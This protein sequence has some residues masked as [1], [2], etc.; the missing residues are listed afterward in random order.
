MRR[1]I[2]FFQLLGILFVSNT[3]F[4]DELDDAMELERS[5]N[6]LQAVTEYQNW[7]EASSGDSRFPDVLIHTASLYTHPV[8][9]LDTLERYLTGLKA[10]DTPEVLVRMA[11][12][13]STLGFPAMA[14]SFFQRASDFGGPDADRW[15]YDSLSLRFLM[16]EYLEIRIE[17]LRLTENTR[18]PV[19]RDN[20]AALA[21]M[22]L[23]YGGDSTDSVRNALDELNRYINKNSPVSSPL[24][25]FALHE[26]A[27]LADDSQSLRLSRN[28][29]HEDFPS[30]PV[31]YITDSKVLNWD[32]PSSYIFRPVNSAGKP[33]QVGAFSSRD[34]AADL[35]FNLENDNF[36]SWI[37]QNGEIWRVF[38]NDPA[39]DAVSRLI[40]AGYD[41]LF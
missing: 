31:R 11:G 29:L 13:S 15:F 38:V 26:I 1:G 39:G 5:G 27:L 36:I 30:S 2:R 6:V 23:A 12:L 40:A 24:L 37:E 3:A 9:A 7:L 17:A 25:W 8:D 28:K 21:A 16:G 18:K 32:S 33:V 35:R 10:S 19:L 34:S 22:S 4:T 20:A 14:A 41:S